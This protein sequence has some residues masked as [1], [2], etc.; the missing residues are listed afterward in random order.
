[1]HVILLLICDGDGYLKYLLESIFIEHKTI[2]EYCAEYPDRPIIFHDKVY[3]NNEVIAT[4]L[5]IDWHSPCPRLFIDH[6]AVKKVKA[7]EDLK[8]RMDWYNHDEKKSK[9]YQLDIYKNV[10]YICETDGRS[11]DINQLLCGSI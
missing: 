9:V 4:Q 1:M 7:I 5:K 6:D 11:F 3:L 2:E 8:Q 10:Y